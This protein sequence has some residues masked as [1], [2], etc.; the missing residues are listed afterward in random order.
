MVNSEKTGEH[1]EP[2]DN[3]WQKM[4]DEA[5]EFSKN[6]S[7]TDVENPTLDINT[8]M[9]VNKRDRKEFWELIDNAENPSEL[10]DWAQ[11]NK[12]N[13][14]FFDRNADRFIYEVYKKFGND[15]PVHS[16]KWYLEALIDR[17][18][19]H[20]EIID[21]FEINPERKQKIAADLLEKID[22]MSDTLLNNPDKFAAFFKEHGVE[23][24]E[25]PLY[26]RWSDYY[27]YDRQQNGHRYMHYYYGSDEHREYEKRCANLSEECRNNLPAMMKNVESIANF[28]RRSEFDPIERY[29]VCGGYIGT[30][31]DHDFYPETPIP[32]CDQEA[33]NKLTIYHSYDD[34]YEII[35]EEYD[36]FGSGLGGKLH[37]LD[38]K[39]SN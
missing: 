28:T 22:F 9:P 26:V 2:Q 24:M 3:L 16:D 8:I 34:D 13:G 14:R 23:N 25:S 11:Q 29:E 30:E 18:D 32:L 36:E 19:A 7:E 21:Q 5:T 15:V 4:A 6:A 33:L 12:A 39:E 37:H 1:A 27:R 10:F 38:P 17:Q 20:P 35:H 31:S